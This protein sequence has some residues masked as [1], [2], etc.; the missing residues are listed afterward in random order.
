MFCCACLMYDC[1]VFMAHPLSIAKSMPPKR[2]RVQ[3]YPKNK[4]NRDSTATDNGIDSGPTIM[5]HSATSINQVWS[6]LVR[7]FWLHLLAHSLPTTDNKATLAKCLYYHFHTPSSHISTDFN[8]GNMAATPLSQT[9]NSQTTI[10]MQDTSP[11]S[12][13]EVF[14]PQIFANQLT[15]LFRHL[16][17]ATLQSTVM[18]TSLATTAM[19]TMG[20]I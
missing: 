9:A 1:C 14:L 10:T 13:H 6:L 5:V 4:Q 7:V 16:T 2:K 19:V 11:P 12:D 15:N 18:E 3:V 8:S 20:R 17:P